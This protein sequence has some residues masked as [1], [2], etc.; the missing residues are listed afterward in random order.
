MAVDISWNKEKVINA[1]SENKDKVLAAAHTSETLEKK[2]KSKKPKVRV[3]FAVLRPVEF[4][5]DAF[6]KPLQLIF[7]VQ[8]TN[9]RVL[10][11]LLVCVPNLRGYLLW[12]V[13][14]CVVVWSS[15]L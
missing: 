8:G 6:G 2:P 3:L 15:L 5:L 14:L 1:V 12:S 13:Y 9:E 11:P 7:A 4:V 10:A